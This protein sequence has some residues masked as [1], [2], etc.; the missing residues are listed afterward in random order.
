MDNSYVSINMDVSPDIV[1]LVKVTVIVAGLVYLGHRLIKALAP[2]APEQP[3][4][5]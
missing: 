3:V 5:A 1:G 4:A 2:A